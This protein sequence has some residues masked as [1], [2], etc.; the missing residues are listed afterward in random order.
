MP[1]E[2]ELKLVV[3]PEVLESNL[4]SLLKALNV[5]KVE[6]SWL[7][8]TYFDT[9]GFSLNQHKVALRIRKKGG[10]YIQTLKTKGESVA[11]VHQ[12]GEWEWEVERNKL[13]PSLLEECVWPNGVSVDA[14]TPVFETN[15]KR[16]S[17]FI[18]RD[19]TKIELAIDI[20][21]IVSGGKKERLCEIELEIIEGDVGRLF[22]VASVIARSFPVMLSDVSKAER[23]YRLSNEGVAGCFSYQYDCAG[24]YE[25][26]VKG[27][28]VRNLSYWLFLFDRV[29]FSRDKALLSEMRD[30]LV[31]LQELV[32]SCKFVDASKEFSH[33]GL[34]AAEIARIG[35]VLGDAGVGNDEIFD[36]LLSSRDGGVLAIEL[37]RWLHA[38]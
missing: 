22:D 18:E 6:E 30:A 1:K 36:T 11:G 16:I 27:L 20:G 2:V 23:G 26:Y 14:L 8:N 4:P 10:R 9:P 7:A 31:V 38:F 5:D 3:L 34:F 24:S 12:R 17:S 28:V 29:A 13:V 33:E 37:G 15:F 35:E 25:G 32:V 19:G 21:R